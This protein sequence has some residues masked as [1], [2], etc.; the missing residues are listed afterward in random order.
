MTNDA[1]DRDVAFR[2]LI[3]A[4]WTFLDRTKMDEA[5]KKTQ[6]YRDLAHATNEAMRANAKPS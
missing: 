2:D 3:R 4:A 6:E 1:P 5:L